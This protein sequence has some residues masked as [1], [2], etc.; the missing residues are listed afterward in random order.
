MLLAN[1]GSPANRV[2]RYRQVPLALGKFLFW[3][4]V[5][6]SIIGFTRRA[7]LSG[8]LYLAPLVA[9]V[10]IFLGL[11]CS[12]LWINWRG[13]AWSRPTQGSFSLA[14]MLGNTGYIGYPVVLLLPQLGLDM[15]GWPWGFYDALE[16]CLGSADGFEP[17]WL[18]N[19]AADRGV[20]RSLCTGPQWRNRLRPGAEKS[21]QQFGPLVSVIAEDRSR[22]P[23]VGL[24]R[25]WVMGDRPVCCHAVSSVNR[26]A[27]PQLESLAAFC[28]LP[29]WPS[30]IK[31]LVLPRDG[32]LGLDPVGVEGANRLVLICRRGMP[33][34]FVQSGSAEANDLDESCRS[35]V[36]ALSSGIF[37]L[38]T[39]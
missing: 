2:R 24:T 4:G 26:N 11:F 5:P 28:P 27:H 14:S 16:R 35:P 25:A 9:W 8:N 7:D 21:F 36:C 22:C 6:I 10:A 31:K 15:F 17:S 29:W 1:V 12:R 34:A 20:W 37:W 19:L 32:R 13:L 39:G 18:K 33:C 30:A 3:V 38:L 23:G